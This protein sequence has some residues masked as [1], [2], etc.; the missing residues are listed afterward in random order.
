V[1]EEMIC[2]LENTIRNHIKVEQQLR[3]YIENLED[4]CDKVEYEA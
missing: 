2:S 4:A 3:L 1:Y